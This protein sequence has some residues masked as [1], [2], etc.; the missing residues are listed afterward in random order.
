[1]SKCLVIV[2]MQKDFVDGSLGSA[3][4]VAIVPAMVE[5]VKKFDGEAIYM[6]RDTHQANYMET[7]EG[8]KLPVVHCV[9]GTQGHLVIPEIAE[10]VAGSACPVKETIDKPTFGS[11]TLAAILK[12]GGFDD[13]YFCGVCTGICVISNAL[14]AKAACYEQSEI[15]VLKDLCACVTE[16]SHMHAL[17]AMKTC[18][19]FVE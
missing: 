5:Y 10:A 2:D 6:T 16:D 15:H 4:A 18:Q 3:A 9:E 1:M 19:I 8:Q 13:I 14:L 7:K 11:E 17:E 12:E